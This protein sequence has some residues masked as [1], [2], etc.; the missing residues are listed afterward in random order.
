MPTFADDHAPPLNSTSR[1][2]AGLAVP[3]SRKAAMLKG[4]RI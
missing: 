3:E 2:R 4:F 1:Q